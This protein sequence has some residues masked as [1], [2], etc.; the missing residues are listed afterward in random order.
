MIIMIMTMLT[1]KTIKH[2]EDGV[3]PW[4]WFFQPWSKLLFPL[5]Y[6]PD[7]DGDDDVD[8]DFDDNQ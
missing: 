1:I 6:H 5:K 3:E 8:N 2:L 7:D 4:V